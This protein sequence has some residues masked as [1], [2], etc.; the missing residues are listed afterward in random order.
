MKKKH[1]RPKTLSG[2][3]YKVLQMRMETHDKLMDYQAI[4][5]NRL[6]FNISKLDLIDIAVNRL[7][8]SDIPTLKE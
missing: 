1:G 2:R 8:D 4:Q 3:G 5:K 6:G 7:Y